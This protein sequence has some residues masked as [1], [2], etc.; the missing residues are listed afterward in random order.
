MKKNGRLVPN[1]IPNTIIISFFLLI[2]VFFSAKIIALNYRLSNVS[3]KYD[4]LKGLNQYY[5]VK[6][7][8]ETSEASIMKKIK[9]MH[10]SLKTPSDWKIK[11]IELTNYKNKSNGKAEASTR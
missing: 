1:W 4:T 7:L 8:E 6:F 10:L 3:N 9:Q 2:H 5:H 11:T